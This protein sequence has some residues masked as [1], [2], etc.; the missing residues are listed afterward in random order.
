MSVSAQDRERI[1][2]AIRAAEARS[3][4]EIVCVLAQGSADATGLSTLIAAVAALALPWIL[5][6]FTALSVQRILFCQVVLFV[7]VMA[8]FCLPGARAALMPRRARRAV[9]HRAAME[10]FVV[11]GIARKKDR[12]GVLIFVSLAERYARVIADDGI[13]AKVPQ[14][15]W[16]GVVD[17]LIAHMRDGRIGDGFV[18]AIGLCGDKL[19][20]HF[21]RTGS[22]RDELPDRLYLI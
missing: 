22:S 7:A 18:V 21:P 15:E 13:A 8:L 1:A 3:S 12:S 2:G 16:Q 10:Q 17:A 20:Q 4:G 6:A 14:K 9:A 11:R 5:V 19:A